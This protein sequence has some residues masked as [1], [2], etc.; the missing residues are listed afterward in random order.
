[1]RKILVVIFISVVLLVLSIAFFAGTYF[2]P[3]L[4]LD[5]QV[6]SVPL[7][8]SVSLVGFRNNIGGATNSFTYRYYFLDKTIYPDAF[9]KR[10][11]EPVRPFLVTSD[12]KPQYENVTETQV[13]LSV[14]GEAYQFSNRIWVRSQGGLVPIKVNFN[15]RSD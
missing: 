13:D 4:N 1:M 2:K 11:A 14:V 10:S 6:L 12:A 8:D 3:Q 5:K 15:A 7:T 9:A